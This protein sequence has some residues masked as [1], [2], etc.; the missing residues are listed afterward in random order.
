M[1]KQEIR[2]EIDRVEKALAK[3]KSEK[4]RNDY[5]KHLKN[6][7]RKLRRFR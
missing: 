5:T 1:T 2:A 3:T 6:L 7:Y 4:L